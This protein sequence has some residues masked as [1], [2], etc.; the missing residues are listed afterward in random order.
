M[1]FVPNGPDIPN[2]LLHAHEEGRVVFFC[3]AGIS[4]PA[5]IPLFKKLV[6]S[7]RKELGIEFNKVQKEE[8]ERGNLDYVLELLERDYAGGRKKIRRTLAKKLQPKLE[9]HNS[10]ETHKALLKLSTNQHGD[11]RLVTTNFDRLFHKADK[12]LRFYSAPA[13]P[14]PKSSR[15]NGVVFLHGHI[16]EDLTD[17]EQLNQ[18]VV[19]IGDFGL[20]YLADGW[21]SKFISELLKNYEVCF[22]GYSLKDPV[23]KYMMAALAAERRDGESRPPVWLISSCQP[24]QQDHERN[25]WQDKG[26]NPILYDANNHDLLHETI[27]K[28]AELY[29]Q[30]VSGKKKL[31][32]QILKSNEINDEVAERMLWALAD[33]SAV[34]VAAFANY[35]PVPR[36]EWLFDVF[37]QKRFGKQDLLNFGIKDENLNEKH[38]EPFSFISHPVPYD[39]ASHMQLVSYSPPRINLDPVM[40]NLG[41]WLLRHLGDLRL[42]LW[43]IEQ[44]GQINAEW[45]DEIRN[46]LKELA[47]YEK[48]KGK[49]KKSYPDPKLRL[50]WRLLLEGR[51]KTKGDDY[52]LFDWKQA[53]KIEGFSQALRL[54]LLEM[55]TLKVRVDK[56]LHDNSSKKLDSLSFTLELGRINS[57]SF[58]ELLQESDS[59]RKYFPELIDDLERLLYDGLKLLHELDSRRCNDSVDPSMYSMPSISDHQQNMGFS[60]WVALIVFLR[61]AWIEVFKVD[62]VRARQI[63]EKWILIPFLTFKRLALF[64]ASYEG[65]VKPQVWRDWLLDDQSKLLWSATAKREVMRLLAEQSRNL[66]KDSMKLEFA[67]L[68]GPV[69]KSKDFDDYD[70]DIWLRLMKM[71]ASNLILSDEAR[72]R[73]LDISKKNPSWKLDAEYQSEEFSGWVSGTGDPDFDTE[74]FIEMH[75]A[76]Y[77][78]KELVEWIKLRSS[79]KRNGHRDNWS[80]FCIEHPNLCIDA[81]S[82]LAKDDIWPGKQWN[83][84]LC[85]WCDK[86]IIEQYYERIVGLLKQ[87]PSS[88]LN[89]FA[90]SSAFWII[91]AIES[92]FVNREDVFV[93][94]KKILSITPGEANQKENS[95]ISYQSIINSSIGLATEA[96]IQML[97]KGG[98]K[99]RQG[100]PREYAELFGKLCL[101]NTIYARYGKLV[102]AQYLNLLF[103]LDSEWTKKWLIPLFDSEQDSYA[104]KF[105]W[106][107]F[108]CR[109][110][111]YD[112]ELFHSLKKLMF[113]EASRCHSLGYYCAE[114]GRFFISVAMEEVEGKHEFE[115]WYH[116]MSSLPQVAINASAQY[117]SKCL[118]TEKDDKC[119][120]WRRKIKPLVLHIWPK[121][122]KNISPVVSLWLGRLCISAEKYFP[123]V[124]NHVS[125]LLNQVEH[126]DSLVENL[127]NSGLCKKFPLETLLFL[128]EINACKVT[129]VGSLSQ[130]LNQIREARKSL[131]KLKEYEVL[132]ERVKIVELLNMKQK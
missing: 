11:V 38:V 127:A 73:L 121:S 22:V 26:I 16:P 64:A 2:A 33:K 104:S 128:G 94:C 42:F 36:L 132:K 88:Y 1:Q 84:S 82:I 31:V 8:F 46:R 92:E 129:W 115:E 54:E 69:N 3:G 66:G 116:A 71:G 120:L 72:K 87:V 47:R 74:Q 24:T 44:G 40:R 86:K 62:P 110:P 23:M 52:R 83:Q 14:T 20:A 34:P 6:D 125:G 79:D 28:W 85:K 49:V 35:Y 4:A 103:W 9:N 126:S 63:A 50:L 5:A 48:T 91:E 89:D 95:D 98:A 57:D 7:I 122:K 117:L 27:R 96:L 53:F 109:R 12:K 10:L 13:L 65:A 60:S 39:H 45:A 119:A 118:E 99:Y 111:Q 17:D 102:L 80:S 112:K 15:W 70:Y 93:V 43:V 76:P 58:K 25:E 37:A 81:L 101:D 90:R 41:C 19:T 105:A 124:F 113:K 131:T 78:L 107:G 29:S 51:I 55:L 100:I 18:L 67:I 114:F 61:E 21:A 130:C 77:E 59:L 123:E 108:I 56:S 32:R 30:G 68:A 75:K 97:L 106:Q